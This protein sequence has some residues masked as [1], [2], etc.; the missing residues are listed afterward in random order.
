MTF[1]SKENHGIMQI[2]LYEVLGLLQHII[3]FWYFYETINI[4]I[5]TFLIG[6]QH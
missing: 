4:I 1:V 5:I 2:W 3:R 6:D